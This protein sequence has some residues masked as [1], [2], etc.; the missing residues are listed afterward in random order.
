M[1]SKTNWMYYTYAVVATASLGA[2]MANKDLLGVFSPLFLWISLSLMLFVAYE[3]SIIIHEAGHL[4]F[5]L[6]TGFSFVSYRYR[7]ILI[8]KDELG[9]FS[10]HRYSI[11]G[12]GGQCLMLPPDKEDVPIFLYNAG[13]VIFNNLQ[14]LLA[15]VIVVL[16]PKGN[17]FSLFLLALAFV[18]LLVGFLNWMDAKGLIND[19]R[20]HRDLKR[21]E[22][23]REA[24]VIVL[25]AHAL[26]SEGYLLSTLKLGDHD[27]T[28]YDANVGIEYNL[29]AFMSESAFNRLD[30]DRGFAIFDVLMNSTLESM[31]DHLVALE[32]YMMLLVYDV[33][34][35]KSFYI[36]HRHSIDTGRKFVKKLPNHELLSLFEGVYLRGMYDESLMETYLSKIASHPL[37]GSVND[38]NR[39]LD[40]FADAVNNL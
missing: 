5:G 35:A 17:V 2:L 12:T 33:E 20:N 11:Q 40:L 16:L 29:L 19:G 39:I 38:N 36:A 23:S 28:Y 25:R 9:K 37:P 26:L 13:G 4:C 24:M 27:Y 15:V 14:A 6:W 3:L 7:D 31:M 34:R 32:Y 21:S 18:G 22:R 10:V 30:F 1:K 8:K